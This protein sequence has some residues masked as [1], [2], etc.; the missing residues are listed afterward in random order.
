MANWFLFA[1]KKIIINLLTTPLK[2][3]LHGV[4]KPVLQK[5]RRQ[6]FANNE[7]PKSSNPPALKTQKWTQYKYDNAAN[8]QK[9]QRRFMTNSTT[10]QYL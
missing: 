7:Y 5:K 10:N 1:T 2:I 8:P 6:Y 4:N 3:F 9:K